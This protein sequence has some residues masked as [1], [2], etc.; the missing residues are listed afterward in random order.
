MEDQNKKIQEMQFLEQHL[1][2]LLMQKQAFQME[3]SETISALKEIENATGEVHKIIGQLMIKADKTKTIEE[4]KNKEK[5]LSLR[6]GSLDKQEEELTEK[7][8]NLRDELMGSIDKEQ[9]S[10]NPENKLSK[11]D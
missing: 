3:L 10:R 4:L 6:M 2:N 1:Q 9:I 8:N 7:A 5:L 11:S